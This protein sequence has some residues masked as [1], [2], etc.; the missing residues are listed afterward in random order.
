MGGIGRPPG[1]NGGKGIP[2]PPGGGI[3]PGIGGIPGIPKG[4]G[5]TPEIDV[6]VHIDSEVGRQTSCECE[7]RRVHARVL[8]KH[9]I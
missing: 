6:R 3:I 9:R 2:R 4:G 5:G 1:G 8:T 7:W